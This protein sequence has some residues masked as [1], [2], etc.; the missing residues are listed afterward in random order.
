MKSARYRNFDPTSLQIILQYIQ[1]LKKKKKKNISALG[2]SAG[3]HAN[4]RLVEHTTATWKQKRLMKRGPFLIFLQKQ[5]R[6]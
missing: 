1:D 3:I 4:V 2:I 5:R 6:L